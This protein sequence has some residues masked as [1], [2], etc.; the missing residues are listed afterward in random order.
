MSMQDG[1]SPPFFLKPLAPELPAVL[2]DPCLAPEKFVAV[3]RDPDILVELVDLIQSPRDFL[4][5]I[6]VSK[7][8]RAV[9]GAA[10]EN[11]PTVRHR[12]FARFLPGH[13]LAT[14]PYWN[15]RLRI[16]LTDLEL[17][18]AYSSHCLPR[19]SRLLFTVESEAVPLS[20]YPMHALMLMASKSPP[21]PERHETTMRFQ[22]LTLTHSRFILYLRSRS[23]LPIA[24]DEDER[25]QTPFG[26]T[27]KE[28]IF[29]APLSYP[30]LHPSSTV[31]LHQPLTKSATTA[32][33]TKA[34]VLQ[35][36]SIVPKRAG[37]SPPPPAPRI[38]PPPTLFGSRRL[39]RLSQSTPKMSPSMFE[40]HLSPPSSFAH[41]RSH[42]AQDTLAASKASDAQGTSRSRSSPQVDSPRSTSRG[43]SALSIAPG[44]QHSSVDSFTG[45]G[46]A[47]SLHSLNRVWWQT[48]AP[49]LRVFVPSSVLDEATLHAC[50]VQLTTAELHKHLAPGDLVINFGYVPEQAESAEEDVGWM[51]YDGERLIPLTHRIPVYNPTFTL[52]SPFYYSHVLP[53]TTNP[54]FVL[55]VPRRR[56]PPPMFTHG[57]VTSTVASVMSPTGRVR[58]N[59]TA[60]IAKIETLRWGAEWI[61]EAEGTKE[62]KAFLETAIASD[63]SGGQEWELVREKCVRGRIWLRR[64]VL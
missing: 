6:Y 25:V 16:D 21:S 63:V 59:L 3:C 23:N 35:R 33:P 41:R 31:P 30:S 48:R 18:R 51:I 4:S 56:T 64:V 13:A 19:A 37:S 44:H 1:S 45:A 55:S 11:E 32:A 12:F 26:L 9:V 57:R 34:K 7:E 62:G 24:V 10:F 58:V 60:W 5:F 46:G 53:S 29:P 14:R 50:M 43:G 54:R 61:L 8:M 39:S 20:I 27:A 49:I 47:G 28:L 17:F 15:P 40:N 22:T 52:P 36:L 42:S 38:S 2:L